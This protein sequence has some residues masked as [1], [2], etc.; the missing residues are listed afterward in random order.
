MKIIQ[1]IE[2]QVPIEQHEYFTARTSRGTKYMRRT[3]Q[4]RR[5]KRSGIAHFTRMHLVEIDLESGIQRRLD[6]RQ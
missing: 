1:S 5:L 3:K 4:L 2:E 6:A